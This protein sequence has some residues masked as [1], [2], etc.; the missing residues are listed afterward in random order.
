MWRSSAALPPFTSRTFIN[1]IQREWAAASESFKFNVDECRRE[2]EAP[3]LPQLNP[4]PRSLI[5]GPVW[6]CWVYIWFGKCVTFTTGV[7]LACTYLTMRASGSRKTWQISWWCRRCDVLLLS[8]VRL[9]CK[10]PTTLTR[11]VDSWNIICS[12][13]G[14]N[15]FQMRAWQWTA[16]KG[17]HLNVMLRLSLNLRKFSIMRIVLTRTFLV[18]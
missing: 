6:R 4:Q 9:I 17:E 11:F 3:S 7:R 13:C 18:P 14:T 12:I 2:K 15:E 16:P 5:L 10:H 8:V 1:Y